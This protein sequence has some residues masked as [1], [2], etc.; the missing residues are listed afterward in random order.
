MTV[1]RIRRPT[2]AP[3]PE[4]NAHGN[5]TPYLGNARDG[6]QA[7]SFSDIDLA[8]N[9][10]GSHVVM[11]VCASADNNAPGGNSQVA[12]TIGHRTSPFTAVAII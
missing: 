3:A 10:N 2:D 5:A 1:P 4:S 9:D 7:P 12:S 11:W 8:L 6:G